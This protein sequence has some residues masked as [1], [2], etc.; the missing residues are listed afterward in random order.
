MLRFSQTSVLLLFAFLA[1]FSWAESL[2]ADVIWTKRDTPSYTDTDS[3]HL[4]GGSFTSIEAYNKDKGQLTFNTD[5]RYGSDGE[6]IDKLTDKSKDTK[7]CV[8]GNMTVSGTTTTTQIINGGSYTS[9][10]FTPKG[11]QNHNM[12]LTMY[13]ITTANDDPSRDPDDWT[14][15]GSNDGGTTWETLTVVKDAAIPGKMDGTTATE[16]KVMFDFP[17][18]TTQAYDQ[19][20]FQFTGTKGN[21]VLFQMAELSLWTNPCITDTTPNFTSNAFGEY[22]PL[23]ATGYLALKDGKKV[24]SSSSTWGFGQYETIDKLVDRNM[25]GTTKVCVVGQG[26]QTDIFKNF[27]SFSIDFLADRGIIKSADETK[28]VDGKVVTQTLNLPGYVIQNTTLNAYA[29]TTGNDSFNRNPE[30][31]TLLGS[32]DKTNWTVLDQMTGAQLPSEK[33][34]MCTIPLAEG[35][36]AYDY[37]RL[38]ITDTKG[39][40]RCLQFSEFSVWETKSAQI[41]LDPTSTIKNVT[42]EFSTKWSYGGGEGIANLKDGTT[43]KMCIAGM[44]DENGYI[45]DSNPVKITFEMTDP[46]AVGSYSLTTA[47]DI[48]DRD[49]SSWTLCGSTDGL[50]WVTLDTIS[51]FALSTERFMTRN[52]DIEND[53]AYKYYQFN[54][55]KARSATPNAFQIGEITFYGQSMDVDMI[56]EPSTFCL[57]GLGILGLILGRKKRMNNE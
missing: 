1:A 29:I 3:Y 45:S 8:T 11:W 32:N 16:R 4:L 56:P 21:N 39:V 40:D 36:P 15:Y 5:Y 51:D 57:L 19:Y 28:K 20:K 10:T 46:I 6:G 44:K 22:I 41:K 23:K 54:F 53:E 49:P 38:T 12:P 34:Q 47:N 24:D 33:Y 7:L 25:N 18:S 50:N 37:Y 42:A 30:N 52:F 14:I 31:W 26:D 55:T 35:T 9:V 17:I 13:S 43:N 27:D 48:P 2:N